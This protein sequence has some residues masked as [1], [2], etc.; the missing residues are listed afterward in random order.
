MLTKKA[1]VRKEHQISFNILDSLGNSSTY[2]LISPRQLISN[3]IVQADDEEFKVKFLHAV[4]CNL[5]DLTPKS[6]NVLC[7][8]QFIA[9][10]HTSEFHMLFV[11][12]I[13][14]C[15]LSVCLQRCEEWQFITRQFSPPIPSLFPLFLQCDGCLF[16][17][18]VGA[19]GW[20]ARIYQPWEKSPSRSWLPIVEAPGRFRHPTSI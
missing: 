17:S 20:V 3:S 1:Q 8:Q 9:Y 5:A 6:I 13:L 10:A 16:L 12:G 11:S 19:H 14:V 18:C 15:T 2:L 7:S 4:K